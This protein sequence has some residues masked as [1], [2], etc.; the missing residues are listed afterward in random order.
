MNEE[1]GDMRTAYRY[2]KGVNSKAGEQTCYTRM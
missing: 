1:V 2:L